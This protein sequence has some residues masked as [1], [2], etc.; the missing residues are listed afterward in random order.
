MIRVG[1]I[2]EEDIAKLNTNV[3]P[4]YHKDLKEVG[5]FIIPTRKACAI[6]NKKY[7]DSLEGEGEEI[8]IKAK[9]F[10]AT[11]KNF[12]PFIDKKEGAIGTTAFQ[13][14]LILKLGAKIIVI[15]NIDTS[16]GLTNGQ[17]GELIKVIYTK[18]EKQIN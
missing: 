13:D 2:N 10:H 1:K 9:Y 5:L 4:K 18:M 16:D 8:K 3:R 12:T 15:H 17:L 14:E 7:L 6:Y 11:Q